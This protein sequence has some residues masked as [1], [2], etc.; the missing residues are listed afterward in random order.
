MVPE[1]VGKILSAAVWITAAAAAAL[2]FTGAFIE[3]NR[4]VVRRSVL[5]LPGLPREAEG[6]KVLLVADTHFGSSFTD[7]LRR[8]RIVKRVRELDADICFLLGDYIAVGGLP[9]WNAMSEKELKSFF[10]SLK[11]PLGCYA[12]LGNHELWYGRR[13]MIRLLESSGIRMIENRM[14]RIKGVYIAGIPE[15][16][17]A[18]FDRQSFEQMIKGHSPLL[19]LTHKGKVIRRIKNA[20]GS[21]T[22]AA[23]THGGQVRIPG[24][25]SLSNLLKNSGELPPGLSTQWKKQLY[26]TTGS[27][28]H[29]WN[30]RLFCPP[31]IALVTLT[32]QKEKE[33]I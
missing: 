12:V 5:E 25:G 30:F 21:I 9:G 14:I 27:G 24:K 28:G 1:R 17:T 15:S 32:K 29:R 4:L 33:H 22:F 31:E 3:P 7:R 2:L 26:I 10:S 16:E 20:P 18:P 11:A 8:D 19:L 13:R 6:M 23:D